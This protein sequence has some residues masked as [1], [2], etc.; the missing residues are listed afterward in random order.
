MKRTMEKMLTASL[1]SAT[2]ISAP[3]M[4]LNIV[5]T[6]D[7]S[8]DTQNI[9]IM[10]SALIDAGHSV[11]MSAPCT[12][13]SGKGGAMTFLKPVS[14]D[15][16]KAAQQ[17]FCVGDT[18]TSVAFADY[19]EGTPVMAVLYGIDVAAQRL[20]GQAPDLVISGPN[21]GNNLGF[22]NNNSGTLGATMIALSRGIPAI[23]VSANENTAHDA[24]QS[25]RV[26]HT[27]VEVVAKLASSR[28]SGSPLLPAYT[29]LNINTPEEMANNLGYKFT[30]VGWNGG[31][32]EFKF[33]DD[34]SGD[35]V[36]IGYMV[37]KLMAGG[38]DQ[39]TAK[40][41]AQTAMQGK[42]GL[43]FSMGDA[44]D[45]NANSEGNAVKASYITISTIDGNV[46][47]ARA[48]VSLTE[49]RLLGLN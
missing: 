18:D 44:G 7:D 33:S 9:Q 36:L 11:I 49:Q 19:A 1:L 40:A 22:M 35:A 23:A 31:G 8:W 48:K 38:M 34:L 39:A 4:A 21:E 24:D 12:G 29:G 16:T 32:I 46:Q 3:V 13:Q 15:E 10:K 26:A 6:N 14:V 37:Q 47:A 43:S 5:L 28:P 17:E 27:V 2:V 41:T 30:D 20:W 45:T 42:Q 25:E